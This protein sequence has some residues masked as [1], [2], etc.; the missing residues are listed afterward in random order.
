MEK[1]KIEQEEL[2]LPVV[3]YSKLPPEIEEVISQQKFEI[4]KTTKLTWDGKQF[5]MRIPTEIAI[6]AGITK[7]TRVLF[8]LIKPLPDSAEKI[9]LEISL[10]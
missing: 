8:H 3:D 1:S 2:E 9:K 10:V 5:S 6:E 4:R 7:E